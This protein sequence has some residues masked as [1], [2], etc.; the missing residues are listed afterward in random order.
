MDAHIQKRFRGVAAKRLSLVECIGEGVSNQQELQAGR[1]VREQLGTARLQDV[2][3]RYLYVGQGEV[4]SEWSTITYYDARERQPHRSPEF[5][6]TYPAS[7]EVMAKAR[8][9]DFCWLLVGASDQVEITV[10]VAEQVSAQAP[11]LDVFFNT[12]L[13]VDALIDVR[14][15]G[16]VF[17]PGR[18]E[19]ARVAVDQDDL[20]LLELLGIPMASRAENAVDEAVRLFGRERHPS[21]AEFSA[22]AR[23]R[24]ATVAPQDDPDQA[25]FDWFMFTYDL[26]L[27]YE[28]QLVQPLLNEHFAGKSNIDVRE[29]FAVASRLKNARFSRAGGSF[30][31]QVAALFDAVGL[32]YTAQSTRMPD[33]S[34]PD[35]L[36]PNRAAYDSIDSESLKLVTFVGAKTTTRERWQQLVAEAQ[37]LGERHMFTMDEKLNQSKVETMSKKGVIPVL[38]LP[39]IRESYGARDF[40]SQLMPV[41]EF[42]ALARRRELALRNR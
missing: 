28:E 27:G 32:S 33:G 13:N 19:D 6:M 16:V 42:I 10:V 38:P 15:D 11:R 25:L 5:R 2:R 26:Y 8:A 39:R 36:L 37:R 40:R 29:F 17:G 23:S 18:V 12:E 31:A 1:V 20:E 4:L 30:E 41:S 24:C 14:R 34:K 35:F 21:A 9:G 7:S 22:F 3:C